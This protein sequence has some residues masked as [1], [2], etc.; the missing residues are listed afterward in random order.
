MDQSLIIE[1][2]ERTDVIETT[3]APAG[4]SNSCG[5]CTDILL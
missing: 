3:G 5:G 2:T 4:G 1:V